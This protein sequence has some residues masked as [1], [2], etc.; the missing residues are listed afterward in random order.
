MKQKK[1]IRTKDGYRVTH[2]NRRRA[3][4]LTC[5]ECQGWDESDRGVRECDGKL[6]DGTVCPLVDFKEMRTTQNA[7]K[8]SRATREFCIACMGGS[9]SLVAECS[10]V[11]CPLYPYR[12]SPN[13][14]R[15]VLFDFD[16][17]DEVVLGATK[18]RQGEI[19]KY[20][21]KAP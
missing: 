11:Y 14:D 10:S 16:I 17:P 21:Q 2:I 6:L 3:C 5:V 1:A 9:I 15:S 7:A 8:R 13:V 20:L 18:T 4:R 12:R 19:R